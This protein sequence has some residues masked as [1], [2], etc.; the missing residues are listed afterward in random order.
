MDDRVGS[1]RLGLQGVAGVASLLASADLP[2]DAAGLAELLT[3]LEELKATAAAL[4]A[5]A[6]VA[7]ADR[8]L[9]EQRAAGVPAARLGRGVAAAVAFAR[10]ESPHAG[11][12]WLGMARA[13]VGEMPHTYRLLERGVL[14]EWRATII[15]RETACLSLEDRRAVDAELCAD[16]R[17]TAWGNGQL[18][19]ETRKIAYRL[20]P[21]SF[22]RRN[23]RAVTDRTVTLR[24]AP[25]GM[26]WL[27]ALL[28]VQQGVACVKALRDA[29]GTARA[30][31]DG[32]SRGQVMADT[33]VERLTG[34]ARADAVGVG[35]HLVMSEDSLFRNGSEPAVVPGFGPVAAAVARGLIAQ[36]ADEGTKSWLRRLYLKPRTGELVG[37]DSRS[38]RFPAGLA[39]LIAARDQ[40]CRTPWCDAPIRHA[41]HVIPVDDG[42]KTS[43]ANGEGLCEACNYAKQAP[44]WETLPRPGPFAPIEFTSPT[45]Q[46]VLTRAPRPPGSPPCPPGSRGGRALPWV[47]IIWAPR[48]A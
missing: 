46:T 40:V 18:A 21:A 19:A 22:V 29:A 34:Q 28:P 15:V 37:L 27:T 17:L 25:D 35:V 48:A 26:T 2:S 42:G 47:D 24:P 5:R 3:G 30:G 4:Q 10:R 7:L 36:A 1:G 6:S 38:R 12:K 9:A 20:D 33:L 13:L 45:G 41:D 8:L 44:G 16:P 23:E 39:A 43:Y 11:D 32:R 14:S 31:G